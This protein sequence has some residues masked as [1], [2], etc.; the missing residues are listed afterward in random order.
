[1]LPLCYIRLSG[2]VLLFVL[3]CL[4][5]SVVHAVEQ[6]ID[7]RGQVFV[8]GYVEKS[9][10]VSLDN[11]IQTEYLLRVRSVNNQG[12]IVGTSAQTALLAVIKVPGG[13][14]DGK[15]LIVSPSWHLPSNT[16]VGV[17][18]TL[19]SS[20]LSSNVV[21]LHAVSQDLIYSFNTERQEVYVNTG[22]VLSIKSFAAEVKHLGYIGFRLP[23]ADY[24]PKL[25][26]KQAEQSQGIEIYTVKPSTISAGTFAELTISGRSF[27]SRAASSAVLFRNV[28]ATDEVYFKAPEDHIRSWKDD[29]IVVWVPSTP[30]GTA[31]TGS[32]Q[33]VNSSGGILTSVAQVTISYA[34][35]TLPTTGSY[36]GN[37]VSPV[38][39]GPLSSGYILT[40]NSV[41]A[42]SAER[43][44]ALRR[45]LSSWRCATGLRVN[46]AESHTTTR[47]P[48]INDGVNMVSFATSTCLPASGVPITTYSY[49]EECLDNQGQKYHLKDFDIILND[50]YNWYSGTG[51]PTGVQYD[52]WSSLLRHLGLAMG[53]GVVRKETATLNWKL[54]PGV[55]LRKLDQ[56]A[57]SLSGA[58]KVSQSLQSVCALD[59]HEPV[60]PSHCNIAPPVAMFVSSLQSGCIPLTV[61][62]TAITEFAA[63]SVKWDL[64]G[65]GI[66]DATG[67]NAS[68]EYKQA[69]SYTVRMIASNGYGSDEIVLPAYVNAYAPPYVN[70]GPDRTTCA[71][72]PVVLGGNPVTTGSPVTI[73]WSPGRFLDDSTVANP[74]ATVSQNTQFVVTLVDS[75]GCINK[76]TVQVFVTHVATIQINRKRTICR[77]GSVQLVTNVSGGLPPFRFEWSPKSFISSAEVL[78][79]TV[80]PPK[81]TVYKLTLIDARGCRVHDSVLVDVLQPPVIDAGDIIEAC[82]GESKRLE[83]LITAQEH[84]EPLSYLWSPALGLSDP[85]LRSPVAVVEKSTEYVLTVTDARGCVVVDTA[86]I[87]VHSINKPEIRYPDGANS[88]E[89][90]P[91]R[92]DAGPGYSAYEWSTGERSRIIAVSTSGKYHVRVKNTFG[93]ERVSSTEFMEFYYKPRPR[94]SGPTEVCQGSLATYS[95]SP[96][97]DNKY[98]WTLSGG[99]LLTNPAS[100]TVTV[101][102]H[103]M[104]EGQVTCLETT[105][106]G[107][108]TMV[109]LQG[110]IVGNALVPAVAVHG[111]LNS[112]Q[113]DSVLLDAGS[114]Y[115]SYLW[116]NGLQSRIIK[117]ETSGEYFVTVVDDLG[118]RGSSVPVSLSFHPSPPKPAV[119]R[120]GNLLTASAADS[121]Q[122]YLD[123]IDIPFAN[124][125]SYLVKQTGN[126]IVVVGT[127][128]GCTTPSDVFPVQAMSVSDH[129]LKSALTF[130]PE[131]VRDVMRIRFGAEIPSAFELSLFTLH[132]ELVVY[133]TLDRTEPGNDIEVNLSHLSSGIYTVVVMSKGMLLT[134]TVVKY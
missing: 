30:S 108:S 22:R 81:S 107:C 64:N 133:Q 46:L 112:C 26:G 62:F 111:S 127:S 82:T 99:E 67:S 52:M 58:R 131:P 105:R 13:S 94:I 134:R 36:T 47:C 97:D 48:S 125:Q 39:S 32:I 29:E 16:L 126:Y 68:F 96:V 63:S 10:V 37:H 80:N 87:V 130:A 118:C 95:V 20:D 61:S 124:A 51:M 9:H 41:F 45:A 72:T 106:F 88:C 42:Q 43:V 1:M 17:V 23:S 33:V 60:S 73:R 27:G 103:G 70:A 38:L 8:L 84:H 57:D 109:S 117:V 93:C 85:T 15:S 50:Q 71:S 76:D 119:L 7:G 35:I 34:H 28:S 101:R 40:M 122:W 116:S 56:T 110:I 74:K 49:F 90:T 24:V 75:R 92:L 4:A 6:P 55:A 14:V 129:A 128:S 89:A 59:A 104:G 86:K 2:K 132:G 25:S 120:T 115:S 5:P 123:D 91:I 53:L 79:P 113:G 54:A 65:D 78:S 102:W 3:T 98:M 21:T 12:D 19:V 66:I 18:G 11:T 31:G 100:A 77:G 114:G 121:Y 44:S 83:P 69:G